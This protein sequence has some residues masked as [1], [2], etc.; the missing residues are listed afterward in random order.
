MTFP[1]TDD[2]GGLSATLARIREIQDMAMPAPTGPTQ[3]AATSGFAQQLATARTNAA[4]DT[5]S[6]V[7]DGLGP[8]TVTAPSALTGVGTGSATGQE[9]ARI[10]SAELGVAEQPPGSNNGPRIAEYRTA[11]QGAGIGPWCSYFTSWVCAQAGVPVGPN[12]RGEGWVPNVQ[13]WGKDTGTWITPS[14]GVPAQVGDLIVFDRNGD[15]LT[16]HIGVVTNVKADGGVDT[17]EG[18]SSDKVSARSYGPGQWTGL[19][20]VAPSA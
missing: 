20:R 5:T 18:N 6:P 16:D 11:T 2:I 8:S 4:L 14:Q 17:V 13:Q 7:E 1:V 12:G 3:A 9:I 15:G 19:V 10:A